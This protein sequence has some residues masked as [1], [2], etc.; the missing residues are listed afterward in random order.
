MKRFLFIFSDTGGGHRAAAQAV[1]DELLRLYGSAIHIDMADIFIELGRW[2]INRLPRWYPAMVKLNGVPWGLGYRLTNQPELVEAFTSLA[3]PYTH[4]PLQCFLQR[5]TPDVVVSFHSI[6]NCALQ[7]EL[8]GL[9]WQLPTAT[10]VLDMVNVHA[11]WFAPGFDLY[12]VPTAAARE[13]ALGW[14]IPAERLEV[15]GMPARRRF[16]EAQQ[17]SRPAA[18]ARLGLP[19]DQPIVL[20]VGGGEGMGPLAPV[21]EA[22][23]R[24]GPDARLIAIAGHNRAL[25]AQLSALELPAPVQVEGFVANMELWLRAA[26]I[27]VTKA[28]PNTLAEAFI[29]GLPLVL[30]AALPGQEA[31]NAAY[32][33]AHGAGIWAPRPDKAA[34]AVLSLLADPQRRCALAA[35]A[36]AL[37]RPD[38]GAAIARRLWTLAARAERGISR[39]SYH[40]LIPRSKF[41][42]P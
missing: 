19:P 5:Y 13:R 4:R 8:R 39:T 31:G 36:R 2:P 33:E 20:L 35:R 40:G 15:I 27:L 25:Y 14:G 3:G 10:V 24:R 12:I 16:V 32:V 42:K 28:G 34:E 7:N 21:V 30:Y 38:A 18:R 41:P 26:D 6:P 37:A 23:A 11:A 22:L 17:L 1:S 9:G 29:A